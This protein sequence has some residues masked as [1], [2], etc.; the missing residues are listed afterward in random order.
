MKNP[1]RLFIKLRVLLFI[2]SFPLCSKVFPQNEHIMDSLKNAV[3]ITKYDTNK[4]KLLIEIGELNNNIPDTL[5]YY[6]QKALEIAENIEEKKF[7]AQCL[8]AIGANLSN[9]GSN[10]KAMEYIEEALKISEEI[11]DKRK[12]TSCYVNIGVINHD[13]GSYDIAIEYYH[14]ALETAKK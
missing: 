7:M 3:A 5:L 10:D 1:S 12:I 2:L 8:I 13:Q 4:V 6:Y 11:N 14:K 9:I